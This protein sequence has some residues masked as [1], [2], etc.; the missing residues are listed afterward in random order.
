MARKTFTIGAALASA[1]LCSSAVYAQ[2][3]PPLL[4]V[5]FTS[6]T[7]PLSPML[8]MAIAAAVAIVAA[9]ALRRNR[10]HARVLSALVVGSALLALATLGPMQ[11]VSRAMA[12]LPQTPLLL[13]TSPAT[14]SEFF[15]GQVIVTNAT[16]QNTTIVA[17]TYNTFGVDYYISEPETTCSVGLALAPGATCVITI[18]SLG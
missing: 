12:N 13:T 8:T 16:G 2:A 15:T 17:I 11:F 7:L 5:D 3:T 14:L 9:I 18:D 6:V 4:E 1:C 10:G